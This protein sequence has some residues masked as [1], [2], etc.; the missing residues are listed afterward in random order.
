MTCGFSYSHKYYARWINGLGRTAENPI[1]SVFFG[2]KCIKTHNSHSKLIK[3]SKHIEGRL[4]LKI[5]L[6]PEKVIIELFLSF[7]Q[8]YCLKSTY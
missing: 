6:G 7:Q 2:D 3:F 5:L 8:Q 1:M 4:A